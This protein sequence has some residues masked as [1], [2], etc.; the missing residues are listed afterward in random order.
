MLIKKK[1][2]LQKMKLADECFGNISTGILSAKTQQYHLLLLC[3]PNP[4][5]L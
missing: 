3:L 4:M 5:S 2:V 1:H